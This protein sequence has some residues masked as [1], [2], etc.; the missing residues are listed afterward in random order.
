LL[1]TDKRCSEDD[2]HSPR[3]K[4]RVRRGT[5]PTP[6][7]VPSLVRQRNSLSP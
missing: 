3:H 7:N 5:L 6:T 1:N 2:F 4:T